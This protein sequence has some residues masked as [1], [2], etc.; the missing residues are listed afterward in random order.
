MVYFEVYEVLQGENVEIQF[1]E[2]W[3]GKAASWGEWIFNE[4]LQEV[5]EQV[6]G[7]K[8]RD[9]PVQSPQCGSSP[10]DSKDKEG[11]VAGAEQAEGWGSLNRLLL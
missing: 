11:S 7:G 8:Q 10:G 4:D 5:E 9:R 3:P 2:R 6:S 1:K